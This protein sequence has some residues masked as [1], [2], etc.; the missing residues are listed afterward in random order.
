MHIRSATLASR[1]MVMKRVGGSR[2]D[3]RPAWR[4]LNDTVGG[5]GSDTT[6]GAKRL[7]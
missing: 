3:P 5:V 6:S 7:Q 4:V 1:A 2:A